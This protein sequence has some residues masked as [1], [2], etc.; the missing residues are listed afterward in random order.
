M[1]GYDRFTLIQRQDPVG[2]RFPRPMTHATNRSIAP[3]M[4]GYTLFHPTYQ[5]PFVERSRNER[6]RN[7]QEIRSNRKLPNILDYIHCLQ[8]CWNVIVITT[9]IETTIIIDRL[10]RIIGDY[11]IY[12]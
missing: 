5:S 9:F 2:A 1:G 10:P 11:C 12:Q 3:P 8:I 6:S 7:E 4:L